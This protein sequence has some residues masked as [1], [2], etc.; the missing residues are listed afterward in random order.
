MVDGHSESPADFKHSR[1][2]CVLFFLELLRN[3]V[4]ICHDHGEKT[5]WY[6]KTIHNFFLILITESVPNESRTDS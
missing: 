1:E 4:D 2:R 3:L 5:M 6:P